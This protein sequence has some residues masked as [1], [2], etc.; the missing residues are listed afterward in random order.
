MRR[1]PFDIIITLLLGLGLGLA[2]SWIFSP[3]HVVDASP[4]AL[5]ADFKDAYRSAIAA[6]Y[7]ATNNL[8]RAQA[9]LALLGDSNSL[10]ALNSQAQRL[11]ASG[12]FAQADQVVALAIAL[13]NGTTVVAASTVTST[14]DNTV[15]VVKEVTATLP[16]PPPDLPFQFTETPQSTDPQIIE[17]QP[18]INTAT[19]RPTRTLIPTVGAPF[20]LIAQDTVCDATLPDGLLQVLVFNSNRRQIA[21]AKIIITWNSGKEQF[22]TGLKPEI[23]H[24]YADYTMSPNIAYTVRLASGS[25]IASELTAPTCQTPSGETFIGGIKLTFQ[26][27]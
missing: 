14:A 24:G 22:F 21:G 6:S 26:Q 18:V 4:I 17:T 20:T 16:P 15:A 25:D 19:P 9:R 11:I 1:I 12:E 27:P 2:Y 10:D 23:S 5:R 3:L 13:E 7:G 8:A